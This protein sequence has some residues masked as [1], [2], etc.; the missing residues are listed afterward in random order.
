MKIEDDTILE[1]IRF[2]YLG[3]IIQ[4]DKEIERDVNH[5]IKAGWKKWCSASSVICDKKKSTTQ[6]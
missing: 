1:V 2:K 5:R 6:V 4:N 3:S